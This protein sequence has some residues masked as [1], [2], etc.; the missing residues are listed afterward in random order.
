MKTRNLFWLSAALLMAACTNEEDISMA[1]SSAIQF[2][3][4][5]SESRVI[6]NTWEKGDKVGI[7]MSAGG[8]MTNNV[9]YTAQDANGTFQTDGT[10]LR[11]PDDQQS[12]VTFYAYYPYNETLA[13][14]K[15]LT[16]DVDGKTDVL[17]ASETVTVDNQ[18]SNTVQLGF[19]H[20]L[21]K[22]ILQADGFPE[23]IEVT[24]SEGYSQATLDIT[25]GTVTGSTAETDYSVNLV[26]E[27]DAVDGVTSYSAI[28]L[29]CTSATKTLTIAS[30]TEGK[31][32]TYTISS[33]TY[34]DG[35]QYAYKATYKNAEG[36]QFT[37][38]GI[39]GWGGDT[40]N[41]EGLGQGIESERPMSIA[42]LLAGKTYVPD[43]N[44]FFDRLAKQEDGTYAPGNSYGEGNFGENINSVYG[45]WSQ[46]MHD[47]C[48]I[49]SITFYYGE[50]G[51]LMAHSENAVGSDYTTTESITDIEVTVDDENKTLAFSKEPF[52]YT[53]VF[54]D[55]K[56]KSDD[57]SWRLFAMEIPGNFTFNDDI[58][59]N[60]D[61]FED[62]KMH[63]AFYSTD[64]NMVVVNFVEKTSTS[65][66]GE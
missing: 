61:L 35:Q 26:K 50:G 62:N 46:E 51:K 11:F 64:G 13:D 31:Q 65:Q 12:D 19:S 41:P 20:A 56:N 29:P 58:T 57:T 59:D 36:V 24:L 14:N 45:L 54:T 30:A 27:G 40:A 3:A 22:V 49:S 43:M 32:W 42:E 28:V 63:W 52:D 48:E 38:N 53:W 34:E 18:S 47:G 7:S 17:W 39:K 4:A 44:Y 25:T 66:T 15:T 33:A 8:S 16:F 37:E 2:N 21:S 6:G 60:K 5:I 1:S 23:D 55:F 10:A 9:L